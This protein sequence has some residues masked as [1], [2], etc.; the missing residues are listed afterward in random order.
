MLDPIVKA[1]RGG[2]EQGSI[3][4]ADNSV[5]LQRHRDWI[6]G[7]EATNPAYWAMHANHT[8]RFSDALHELWQFKNP[9]LLEAGPG[10]T[11]GVLAMQHPDRRD[12]GDPVAVSSIRHHYENQSDVEFLWH[13]IGRLWLS[14]IEIKWDNVHSGE[15]RRRV[16]LPTYPFER[17]N[18]WMEAKSGSAK[19]RTEQNPV[20][21]NSG[22]DDW[23]YVPTWERTPFPREITHDP[24][25]RTLSG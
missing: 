4:R 15:Q 16:S 17:Q 5:H 3:E 18:Y 23:F 9:I 2:S 11:L 24:I 21:E 25:W 22:V 10:R 13:G 8:A 1:F 7:R 20:S 6:T 19:K 12:A 14:G